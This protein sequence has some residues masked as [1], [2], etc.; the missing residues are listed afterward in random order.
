MKIRN[1]FKIVF[2]VNIVFQYQSNHPCNRTKEKR[3]F[4]L[5]IAVICVFP[6]IDLNEYIKTILYL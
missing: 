4:F 5:F 6:V 1:I 3:I 2:C